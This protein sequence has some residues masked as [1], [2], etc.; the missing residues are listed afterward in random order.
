MAATLQFNL[1][2]GSSNTDPDSSLGGV[3]STTQVSSTALNNIF[4][5]VDPTE[6]STGDTEYRFIDVYNS[7][8]A[9]A[10]SVQIYISSNTTSTDTEIQIGQDAT[11]NPHL[12]SANLE[13]LSNESTAPAS[14]V[15]IF[16]THA[17]GD[18]LDLTDIPS[19]SAARIC[20][21]RVV[22]AAAGN[23]SADTATIS[24]IYA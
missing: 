16:G 3:M 6:A 15:I 1:T 11:N 14:P 18:E 13:T 5:N 23:T 12:S 7:G 4:D 19:G 17:S 24:V 20:I 22:S 2:G 8:D 10:T 9:T 21:K